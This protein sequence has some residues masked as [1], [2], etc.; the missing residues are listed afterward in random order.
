MS[1]IIEIVFAILNF[2]IAKLHA[3]KF[4]ENIPINSIFHEVW[5]GIILVFLTCAL[6][7][8][9]FNWWLFAALILFRLWFFSPMLNYLREPRKPFFYLHG[10]SVNGS[11]IDTFQ[12]S[13]IGNAY[14]WFWL[15]YLVTFIIL[16]FFLHG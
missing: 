10:E 16:Q 5:A 11:F 9:H 6:V 1:W 3:E 2:Y 7:L 4:N 12:E 15:G 14:P 8:T 13:I